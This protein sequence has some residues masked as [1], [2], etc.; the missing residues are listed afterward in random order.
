[1]TVDGPNVAPVWPNFHSKERQ[2]CHGAAGD[3][4]KGPLAREMES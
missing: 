4:S 1:M 3:F 2:L